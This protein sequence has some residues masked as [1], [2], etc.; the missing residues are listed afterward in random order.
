MTSVDWILTG[1]VLLSLLVGLWRGL[2]FEVMSL[3]GWVAAFF[4][5]Q[6]LAVFVAL[7]LPLQGLSDSVRYAVGFG[8]TFLVCV[9]A[10]G[11]L[12]SLSRKLISVV[13]LRPVDRLMGAAFGALRGLVILLALAVV[14]DLTPLKTSAWWA[15]S[16]IAPLLAVLLVGLKPALPGP[17][18]R[19]LD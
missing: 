4:V 3:V 5:A 8:L 14:I 16:R 17:L 18:S 2:V 11:L 1:I 9:M 13:G 15:Q 7:Q 10:A 12:A 19:F 6:W